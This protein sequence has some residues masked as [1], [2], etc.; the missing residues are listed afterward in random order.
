MKLVKYAKVLTSSYFP[1]SFKLSYIRVV[2][3]YLL[4]IIYIVRA[5]SLQHW[6]GSNS[7]VLLGVGNWMLPDFLPIFTLADIHS[8]MVRIWM[9]HYS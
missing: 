1:I 3:V 2:F 5:F 9:F 8:V 6:W 7:P 4:K